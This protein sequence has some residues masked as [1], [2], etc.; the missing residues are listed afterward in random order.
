MKAVFAP[1]R[2]ESTRDRVVAAIREAILSG[3][4]STGQRLAEIPLAMEFRVSRAVVREA[5][6]QL[7]HEG[8]VELSSFRGAQVVDLT[9]AEVDEIVS[10]RLLLEAEAVRLARL[11]MKDKDRSR[12]RELAR[13]LEDSRHDT[14]R[15]AQLD[16]RFHSTLWELSGNQTLCRHLVLL[17]R[18]MFSMGTIVRHSRLLAEDGSVAYPRGEHK[19]LAEKICDGDE[20]EAIDAIRNHIL[21]NWTRAR[22]AIERYREAE[23]K[24]HEPQQ[25]GGGRPE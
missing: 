12:L 11:R 21:E 8:L 16:M 15:F 23:K 24:R 18:P 9:P 25:T 10:V 13:E 3:R 20:R 14:Q 6:Q 22:S 19:S 5:L 17:T 1:V 4:L 7:A 2:R